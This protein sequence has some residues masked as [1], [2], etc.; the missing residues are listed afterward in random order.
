MD[1]IWNYRIDSILVIHMQYIWNPY[2]KLIWT[3]SIWA[4]YDI[5]IGEVIK[6]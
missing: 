6:R 3:N 1:S 4:P 5:A 2:G